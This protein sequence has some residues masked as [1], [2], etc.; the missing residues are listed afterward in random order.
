MHERLQEKGKGL[1]KMPSQGANMQHRALFHSALTED[2]RTQYV[3]VERGKGEGERERERC[4]REKLFHVAES[5]RFN[6]AI[7]GL[8]VRSTGFYGI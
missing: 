4:E 1:P 2:A 6:A 8:F 5:S 3:Y 7:L